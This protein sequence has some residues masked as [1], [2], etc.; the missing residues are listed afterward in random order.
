MPGIPGIPGQPGRDG[1]PGSPGNNG[2][3][4]EPGM[5]G[6]PADAWKKI[7]TMIKIKWCSPTG[8][9]VLGENILKLIKDLL[10]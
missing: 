10:E 9:N 1:L 2:P 8:N 6:E 4:G 7:V 3:K 5:K